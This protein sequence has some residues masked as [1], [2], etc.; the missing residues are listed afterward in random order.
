MR[1]NANQTKRFLA[2]CLLYF[3]ARHTFVIHIY[4]RRRKQHVVNF[5]VTVD[6]HMIMFLEPY[7]INTYP[8]TLIPSTDQQLFRFA[9]SVNVS[10]MTDSLQ[11][12]CGTGHRFCWRL[13]PPAD[14]KAS[15]PKFPCTRFFF[16]LFCL[17]ESW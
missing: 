14:K 2:C 9:G 13:L 8:S 6:R 10:W 5:C 11:D 16:R 12:L 1:V 15:L 4:R 17:M 3:S 7:R